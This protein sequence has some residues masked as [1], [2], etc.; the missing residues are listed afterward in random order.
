MVYHSI[1]HKFKGVSYEKQK[2]RQ[3]KKKKIII[4]IELRAQKGQGSR[5]AN[6]Y[7]TYL[8]VASLFLVLPIYLYRGPHLLNFKV[9]YFIVRQGGKNRGWI[10]WST[11]VK[12]IFTVL[13]R[14]FQILRE[15][16]RFRIYDRFKAQRLALIPKCLY[17]VCTTGS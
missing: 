17:V 4:K 13:I 9:W 16:E 11:K 2:I 5:P 8:K 6:Y 14:Y 15:H 7:V 1:Y 3:K 12:F 10:R